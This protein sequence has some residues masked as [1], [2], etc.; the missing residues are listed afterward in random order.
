MAE[1]RKKAVA[2]YEN[3]QLKRV[4][5][6]GPEAPVGGLDMRGLKKIEATYKGKDFDEIKPAPVLLEVQGSNMTPKSKL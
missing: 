5:V 6:F 3:G 1:V 4:D 2:I